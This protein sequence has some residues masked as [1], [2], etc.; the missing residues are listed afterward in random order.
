M[1]Q[2]AGAPRFEDI[3]ALRTVLDRALLSRDRAAAFAAVANA[4]DSG[5]ISIPDL[6]TLVLGPLMADTGAEWQAGATRVWEEHYA[7]ATVRTIVES[8]AARVVE[9]ADAVPRRGETALLA[10]PPDEYHD[11]G[12]RMLLDRMLLAGYDAHFLG[13]DTPVA[14]LCDAAERLGATLVVLSASTHFHRVRLRDTMAAL[15][16][17]LPPG[18]R[19]VAGGPA[20]VRDAA[21]HGAR[22]LGEAELG[23]PGRAPCSTPAPTPGAD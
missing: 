11:L 18:T 9:A 13:A 20:F 7:S 2:H 4:V 23:L 17:G 19:V 3:S 5:V 6:Y 16:K 14:E 15:A 12:L 21:E 8:L 1:P 22:T 10:C